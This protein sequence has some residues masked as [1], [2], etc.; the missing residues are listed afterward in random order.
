MKIKLPLGRL[1]GG[2][3]R[4]VVTIALTAAAQALADAAAKR[5]SR[6]DPPKL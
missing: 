3:G 1:L 4:A 5:V 2:A 6:T